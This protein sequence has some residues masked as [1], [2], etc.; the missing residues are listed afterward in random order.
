MLL[1]DDIDGRLEPPR[2]LL[3]EGKFAMRRLG[4][5][6]DAP[7]PIGLIFREARSV[8]EI[9]GIDSRREPRCIPDLLYSRFQARQARAIEQ[10]VVC[11][12]AHPGFDFG[13]YQILVCRKI[14]MMIFFCVEQDI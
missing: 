3:V 6:G 2:Q 10:H 5:V 14:K 7:L 13:I 9:A 11:N 1:H 12:R 4:I 8:A